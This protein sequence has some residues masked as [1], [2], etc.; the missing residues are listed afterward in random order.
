M[1]DIEPYYYT[2][3]TTGFPSNIEF[4]NLPRFFK[5]Y[6]LCNTEDK[7]KVC[8]YQD[9]NDFYKSNLK[10]DKNVQRLFL[11]LQKKLSECESVTELLGIYGDKELHIGH[12]TKIEGIKKIVYR[13]RKGG[14]RLYFVIVNSDMILFRLSIKLQDKISES[15]KNIIDIRVKA[16]FSCPPKDNK[17]L[18]R[19]L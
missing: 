4:V 12:R 6:L 2:L 10:E 15:E 11:V 13:I 9:R 14:V 18:K 3:E 19:I 17:F 8:I 1:S 16:I 5:V 7:R